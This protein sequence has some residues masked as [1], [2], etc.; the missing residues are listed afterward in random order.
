IQP[1]SLFPIHSF[2]PPTFFSSLL[3]LS[4]TLHI[5]FSSHFPISSFLP[6]VSQS[7]SLP[8][9]IG[10]FSLFPIRSFLPSILQFLF[11]TAPTLH[12]ASPSLFPL[13]FSLH[14]TL[15]FSHSIQ[16]VAFPSPLPPF[17]FLFPT[18]STFH[19]A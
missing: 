14:S 10:S 15:P 12:I 1:S 7:F 5:L 8:P 16:S 2:L 11:P 3:S 18:L 6:L 13:H 19:Q 9:H 4:L 17:L